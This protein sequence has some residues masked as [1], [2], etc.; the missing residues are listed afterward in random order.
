MQLKYTILM[1][2]ALL[3]STSC[4]RRSGNSIIPCVKA[5]KLPT[6]ETPTVYINTDGSIRREDVPKVLKYTANLRDQ[7]YYYEDYTYEH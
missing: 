7:I 4:S 3:V 1:L 6:I 2:T 5:H